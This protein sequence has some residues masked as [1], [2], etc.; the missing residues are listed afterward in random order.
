MFH[1]GAT[2]I[3]LKP[4]E[5]EDMLSPFVDESV[6]QIKVTLKLMEKTKKEFQVKI[7]HY[8]SCVQ[9]LHQESIKTLT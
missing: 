7:H 4:S 2:C 8:H 3:V 1:V 9:R 6:R 5:Y